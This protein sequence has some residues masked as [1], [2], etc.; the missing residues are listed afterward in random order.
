MRRDVILAAVTLLATAGCSGTTGAVTPQGLARE[1]SLSSPQPLLYAVGGS[2]VPAFIFPTKR[3]AGRLPWL[4]GETVSLCAGR[5]HDI[6][7]T[8][9]DNSSGTVAE[10]APGGKKALAVMAVPVG[11]PQSC[12]VD[13]KTGN[14]AV[15]ANSTV[16]IFPKAPL[17]PPLFYTTIKHA[18][19]L[20]CTYDGSG[21]LFV[22]GYQPNSSVFLAELLKGTKAFTKV[23][24]DRPLQ[25]A[26]GVQ[27][28]G[29]NLAVAD[30]L[31]TTIYQMAVN[32]GHAKTVGTTVLQGAQDLF[33]P[34]SVYEGTVSATLVQ[35]GGG[36][37]AYWNYPQG[38]SPVLKFSKGY[39]HSFAVIP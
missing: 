38:G 2:K 13:A 31:T 19:N 17:Y 35:S 6:W 3:L 4:Y 9:D 29:K 11:A 1:S 12:A 23:A 34:F 32:G 36:G 7:A 22:V 24:L 21:D 16:A 8:Q 14:L 30:G 5:H 33:Y 39:Y 28:D 26:G 27:W 15:P 20:F 10:Y 18:L 37:I 25:A